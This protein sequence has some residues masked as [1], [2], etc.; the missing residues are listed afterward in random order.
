MT[1][2]TWHVTCDTRHVTHGGEWTFSQNFIFL[3]LT[4]WDLWCC[5]DLE[6]KIDSLN[7]LLSNKGVWRTA[8]ATPGLLK[9]PCQFRIFYSGLLHKFYTMDHP[10]DFMFWTIPEFSSDGSFQKLYMLDHSWFSRPFQN[11]WIWDS[12]KS[13]TFWTLLEFFIFLTISNF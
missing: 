10:R 1:P 13:F 6:E 4:V 12:F 2:D 3:A 7:R 11:F 5:E 9:S 8:P